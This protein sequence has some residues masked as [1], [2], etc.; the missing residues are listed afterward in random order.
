MVVALVSYVGWRFSDA[1]DDW[2]P[3]VATEAMSIAITVLI[4][5]RIVRAEHRR[6]VRPRVERV[7]SRIG[8]DL[9]MFTGAVVI[10]YA[11]THHSSF[12]SIPHTTE[13]LLDFWLAEQSNEDAARQALEGEW[14]PMVLLEAREFV[15]H[16][17][18]VRERDL[19]VME[20]DLVSALDDFQLRVAQA[21]N[22]L[23]LAHG[24]T[25]DRD[26]TARVAVRNVVTGARDFAAVFA[27]Y[28]P[29]WMRIPELT[30]KAAASHSRNSRPVDGG[31]F[32][33][34]PPTRDERASE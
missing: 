25:E 14:L 18:D 5:E 17:Q 20:P 27:R 21:I 12:R 8:L 3:N 9:R 10:D 26:E 28:G 24:N 33:T 4:V 13:A 31:G 30:L 16:L 6:R 15:R 29:E 32:G 7:V 22:L 11:G 19:D 1:L 23:G 34:P 2:A